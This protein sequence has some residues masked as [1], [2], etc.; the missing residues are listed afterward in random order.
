VPTG[1]APRRRDLAAVE[2]EPLWPERAL[3][4]ID[5][6]GSARSS[7]EAIE[8]AKHQL[9]TL[10]QRTRRSRGVRGGYRCGSQ[11]GGGGR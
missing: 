10:E 4:H 2:E 6:R 5:T 8:A 1:L 3:L 11:G 9:V 7:S